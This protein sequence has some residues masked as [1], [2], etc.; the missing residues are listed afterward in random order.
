VLKP[1]TVAKTKLKQEVIDLFW[2][3]SNPQRLRMAELLGTGAAQ[4]TDELSELVG[5]N[6]SSV[7]VALQQFRN[8]HMLVNLRKE[9]RRVFYG[10]DKDKMVQAVLAFAEALDLDLSQQPAAAKKTKKKTKKKK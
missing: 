3:L 4:T 8:F 9:G 1:E 10:L 7:T 6:L 2:L 5:V